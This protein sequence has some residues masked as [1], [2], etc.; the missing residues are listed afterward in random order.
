MGLTGP[1]GM[2]WSLVAAHGCVGVYGLYRMVRR[3]PVPL[4]KQRRYWPVSLRTSPIV[5]ALALRE[6]RDSRD[7]D[8]ARWSGW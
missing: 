3:D 6:V 8:L 5:Q 1:P 2:F 7:R 4:E